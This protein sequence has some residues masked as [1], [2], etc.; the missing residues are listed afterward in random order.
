MNAMPRERP[1]IEDHRITKLEADVE[2]L[3]T[4]MSEAKQDIRELQGSVS[5]LRTEFRDFRIEV[6][7]DF[8]S[9]RTEMATRFGEVDVR[10]ESLRTESATR[11]GEV[12]ARIETFRTETA[13]RFG[14]TDVRIES[15]RTEMMTRFGKVDTQIESVK[16]LI[17]A[18]KTSTESIKT[19]VERNTR[20]LV[21]GGLTA[22]A[23]M[24]AMF[25]TIGH[26]LK[27]F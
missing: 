25:G 17:E 3:C 13:T 4:E 7:K 6:A 19:L 1:M 26:A 21:V 18:Q 24:V 11:F 5:G 14:A 12:D 22:L 23:T 16:T 8:G 20:L 2:H 9:V 15:L 10:T 27:W